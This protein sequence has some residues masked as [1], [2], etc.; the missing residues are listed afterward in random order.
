[1]SIPLDRLYHYIENVAKSV[2]EDDVIIYRFYPHG[3][4]KLEDLSSFRLYDVKQRY[5]NLPV[6]C[7]DQEPLQYEFYQNEF[8]TLQKQSSFGS[9]IN[10]YNLFIPKNLEIHGSIYDRS[11]LLHSEKRSHNLTLYQNNGYVPAYYW[12][13]AIISRDWFRFA[14]HIKQNKKVSRTFLIYNRAWSGTREYRL[15][16]AELL[17]LMDLQNYCQT[18]VNPIEPELDIHY[19]NHNFKNLIWRPQTVLENYFSV[20]DAHSSYS[21]NFNI[22]DYETTD[23]EIVL[24]TLFDD[25][26]LHLT[27]KILRPIACGQPFIL[28]STPGSLEYLRSY[29]FKT[30]E[31]IWDESYDQEQDPQERMRMIADLMKSIASWPED[32]REYNMVKAQSIADFN[33]QYF[34]SKEFFNIVVGELQNNLNHALLELKKTNTGSAWI[35]RRKELSKYAEL[36]KFLLPNSNLI[37]NQDTLTKPTLM[38]ILTQAR[39]YY[40]LHKN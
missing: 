33:K 9:L 31:N 13:H 1:M 18:T 25:D 6:Y 28:A 27:E 24:E 16:F 7:N 40:R 22:E 2:C 37:S 12:S 38:S 39:N 15:R 34:F 21:A 8:K 11:V 5:T 17:I 30:F 35:N 29:G 32:V 20:S 3:S 23:V 10:Q 26:R 36:K 4:K 19:K 14:E